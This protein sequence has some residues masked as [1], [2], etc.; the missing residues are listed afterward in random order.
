MEVS[1]YGTREFN[2]PGGRETG[3]ALQI[4]REPWPPDH[5][6]GEKVH[7]RNAAVS[8]YQPVRAGASAIQVSV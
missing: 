3:G 4:E 2:N 1:R 6:G 7:A 5:P 8:G